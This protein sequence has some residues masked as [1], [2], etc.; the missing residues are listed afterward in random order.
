VTRR[1]GSSPGTGSDHTRRLSQPFSPE[2]LELALARSNLGATQEESDK[3]SAGTPFDDFDEPS[4]FLRPRGGSIYV[5][6]NGQGTP[7]KL[8]FWGS[9]N[10]DGF[11]NVEAQSRRASIFLATEGSCTPRYERRQSVFLASEVPDAARN[12][13]VFVPAET[14]CDC[15]PQEENEPKRT[16][17]PCCPSDAIAA[18]LARTDLS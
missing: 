6:Y 14:A 7:P 10:P 9:A 13:S 4:P 17:Q 8:P 1:T 12:H 18:I 3:S 2:D 15:P 16:P 5:P 11:H